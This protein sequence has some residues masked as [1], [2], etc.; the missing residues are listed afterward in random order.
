M[1]APTTVCLENTGGNYS[2]RIHE[3]RLEGFQVFDKPTQFAFGD[4]T[5]L[6][7]PNSSGKSALSDAIILLEE[8]LR[9]PDGAC[10]D[11]SFDV[12]QYRRFDS[13]KPHWRR[14]G[15]SDYDLSPVMRIGYT[16]TNCVDFEV[17]LR[18]A[19]H[20]AVGGELMGY[21]A[22]TIGVD[23]IYRLEPSRETR[24]KV[25]RDVHVAL[26]SVPIAILEE[27]SGIGINLAHA[28][29]NP[30]EDYF[31]NALRS[32]GA[33][34]SAEVTD[35]WLWIRSG[36]VFLHD[37][38]TLDR[39]LFFFIDEFYEEDPV[40][41]SDEVKFLFQEVADIFD[42]VH[43]KG[44]PQL[45]Y[46][47]LASL[48]P[49]SRSIPKPTEL[50]F[51]IGEHALPV[52]SSAPGNRLSEGSFSEEQTRAYRFL[53]ESAVREDYNKRKG[54]SNT[55][56]M[57]VGVNEAL[58]GAL[59]IEHGYQVRAE[60]HLLVKL[61]ELG[62][63]EPLLNR[64]G[65]PV[66][67]SL[68]LV[69]TEGRRHSVE[70]VGSGIGYVLPVLCMLNSSGEILRMIQQPEL[71]LH[72]ALQAALGDVFIQSALSDGVQMLIETHS[73]Y[74]LLRILRRI[75]K[76]R[77]NE[78]TTANSWRFENGL[79]VLYFEPNLSGGTDV[80]RL[81]ISRKGF[82]EDSWPKGFFA[83]RDKDLFGD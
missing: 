46:G 58:S 55:K 61:D 64:T 78:A 52:G 41:V 14:T 81:R 74:L 75:R 73:E 28:L 30:V 10:R 20:L 2:H 15:S 38:R 82:F 68:F 59:F 1:K 70:A 17:Q 37:D 8:A 65:C 6:L 16:G 26:D 12:D 60:M 72:P 43:V 80:R 24:P 22:E 57:I 35:G 42:V 67:T 7:G 49:A 33:Q 34:S 50:T 27:T 21:A 4:I 25:R 48:V 47:A 31:Y 23:L 66:R 63:N 45:N 83:E 62:N 71:H 19:A 13:L 29:L 44:L 69:D 77:T 53:A 39:D 32:M 40:S 76:M 51:L 56:E 54:L 9:A 36:H 5:L 11:A 3:I 79:S 18:G